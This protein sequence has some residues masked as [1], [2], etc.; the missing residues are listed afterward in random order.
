[1]KYHSIKDY[2]R[3]VTKFS[4]DKFDARKREL[5]ELFIS[6]PLPVK[7]SV[8][9]LKDDSTDEKPI[10]KPKPEEKL[11]KEKQRLLEAFDA[12]PKDSR[13]AIV[14]L[15]ENFAAKVSESK[16]I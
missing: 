8:N 16:S 15:V 11:S 3:F 7:N 6:L 10:Q 9:D 4:K 14:K 2:D 13:Q 1:M 5:A 12:L